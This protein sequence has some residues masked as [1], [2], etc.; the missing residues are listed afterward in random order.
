MPGRC[1]GLAS[2]LPASR[3]RDSG[4]SRPPTIVYE[5]TADRADHIGQARGRGLVKRPSPGMAYTIWTGALVGL[6][7][8]EPSEPG[9]R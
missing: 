2:F 8:G 4:Q 5:V 3:G 9:R 1:D 7:T 6:Q